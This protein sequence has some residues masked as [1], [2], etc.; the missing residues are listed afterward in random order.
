[1]RSKDND[2]EF[3]RLLSLLEDPNVADDVREGAEKRVM[4]AVIQ[5]GVWIGHGDLLTVKMVQ[6]A[7]LLMKGSATAFGRLEFLLG[8]FRL[9]LLH[10]KMKKIAQDIS[11]GMKK[12]INFDDVLSLSWS[13][14]L[15]RVKISN[16]AKDIKKNDSSFELHDQF[17]EAVQASYLVNMY[18]NYTADYPSKLQSIND[19]NDVTSFIHEMLA[20]YKIKL[21]YDPTSEDDDTDTNDDLYVYCQVSISCGWRKWKKSKFPRGYP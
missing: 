13:S 10:M 16:K 7:K 6:E 1:M 15:T 17:V 2:P 21:Y 9:Q 18:D 19:L 5:F 14:A 11:A 3:A 8:P 4:E 20:T 12:L